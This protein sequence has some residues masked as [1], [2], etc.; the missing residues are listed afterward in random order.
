MK[1]IVMIA[2]LLTVVLAVRAQ[3]VTFYSPEFELGVKMHL[4]LDES[5]DVLQSQMDAITEIDLSGLEITDIRDVVYLP[6]VKVLNLSYN[7]IDD[8]SSLLPLDSLREVNLSNNRLESINILAFVEVDS[9]L[10]DISN[11]SIED[12]SFFY[13]PIQCRFI[14]IGTEMQEDTDI[15]LGDVNGE[16]RVDE[17]D[18]QQILD[19]SA[20][21]K[22]LGELNVPQATGVPGGSSDALEVNAQIVLDYSVAGDK[23]W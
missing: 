18:A 13:A 20:G 10:V 11:N 2:L 19:V 1:K 8:V 7:Y 22:S 23:P 4:G 3:K 12:L 6:N 16:G 15:L 21:V 17:V 14:F 5:D 9:M